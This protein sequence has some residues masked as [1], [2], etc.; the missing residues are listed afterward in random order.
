MRAK[1]LRA[2]TVVNAT[3]AWGLINNRSSKSSD[4]DDCSSAADSEGEFILYTDASMVHR[5]S[6]LLKRSMVHPNSRC[7]LPT[8]SLSKS[9][10][11]VPTKVHFEKGQSIK[12]SRG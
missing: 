5:C 9:Q 1:R 3:F 10:L 2:I 11:F 6:M 8:T 4:R 7:M 12:I